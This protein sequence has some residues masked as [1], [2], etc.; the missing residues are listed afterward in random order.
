MD[1]NAGFTIIAVCLKCGF[2]GAHVTIGV[3][4]GVMNIS[5]ECHNE[6]CSGRGDRY[7]ES[8]DGPQRVDTYSA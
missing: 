1:K 6:E 3:I 7:F 4:E 2:S 5:A 8:A